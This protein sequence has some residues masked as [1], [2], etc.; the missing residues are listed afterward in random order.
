MNMLNKAQ[1]Q[2]PQAL[3]Q[4]LEN[5]MVSIYEYWRCQKCF[6]TDLVELDSGLF[7]W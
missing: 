4:S 1:E 2:S 6:M 3:Y 5:A 7:S